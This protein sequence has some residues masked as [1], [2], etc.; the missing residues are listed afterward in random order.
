[1]KLET[2]AVT[3]GKQQ[4]ESAAISLSAKHSKSPELHSPFSED[5]NVC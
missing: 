5:G 1:M 4:N 2:R 3:I